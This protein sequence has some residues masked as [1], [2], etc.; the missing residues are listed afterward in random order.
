MVTEYGGC[1]IKNQTVHKTPLFPSIKKMLDIL[2][3]KA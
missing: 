1:I 2:N 3:Y